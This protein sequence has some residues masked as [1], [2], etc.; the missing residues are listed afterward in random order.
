MPDDEKG[1]RENMTT[2]ADV[3]TAWAAYAARAAAAL[4]D[5]VPGGRTLRMGVRVIAG[6]L[7][8]SANEA[9]RVATWKEPA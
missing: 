4:T 6:S 9:R 2:L 5:N 7:N 3:L 1:I 8:Y